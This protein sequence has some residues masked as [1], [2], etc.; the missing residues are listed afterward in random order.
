[1]SVVT[2][3]A[4][5]SVTGDETT[6]SGTVQTWL[7]DT[8]QDLEE[9]LDRPLELGEYTDRLRINN[10]R[11][12]PTVY[13]RAT[14]ITDGGDYLVAGHALVGVSPISGMFDQSDP[15]YAEVTYTGGWSAATLPRSI[16]HDICWA[17]RQALR[18]EAAMVPAGATSVSVG[19]ASVSFGTAGA[20]DRL[21]ARWSRQTRRYRRRHL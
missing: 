17:V 18:G 13:P 14:P 16:R 6:A 21:D 3:A 12:G 5:R 7:D 2:I 20:S 4:Y 11:R 9:Y 15:A 19:D 10:E 8:E 1:M